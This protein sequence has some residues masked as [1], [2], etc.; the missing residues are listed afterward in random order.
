MLLLEPI[1]E[2]KYKYC[3]QTFLHRFFKCCNDKNSLFKELV[4]IVDWS[5]DESNDES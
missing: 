1:S 4:E 2:V 5:D 3:P